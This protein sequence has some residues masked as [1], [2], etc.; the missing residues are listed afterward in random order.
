MTHTEIIHRQY[1]QTLI[2]GLIMIV[3]ELFP[4]EEI[5]IQ[6]SILDGIYCE[7]KNSPLSPREVALIEKKLHQ[8]VDAKPE[9]M[10]CEEEDG[11]YHTKVNKKF[12]KSLYPALPPAGTYYPFTLIFY[13][14]G[15]IL[16]FSN[17]EHPSGLPSFVPPEKLTATFLESQRWVENLNLD[18]V[19]SI[20]R[21]ICQGNTNELI[22]LAEA[23][24]EKKISLIADRILA[25]KRNIRIIL[26]SGPSSSGKTT[27]AQRLSTQ[28]R[29]NGI[30]PIALSLDDYFCDREKTPLDKDGQYDFEALEA[31]DLPLLNQHVNALIH[32]Q[33]I[34][35]PIYDFVSG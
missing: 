35:C 27:F 25:Q 5:K 33:E 7:L 1:R 12:V 18:T 34:E 19:D 29:V 31:L 2:F 14:P 11:F 32:G 13:H 28:L 15:F 6:Y 9:I 10:S 4:E 3:E 24:H 21:N 30:R 8:W 26:I 16:L 20:N 17:P 23:L 22:A